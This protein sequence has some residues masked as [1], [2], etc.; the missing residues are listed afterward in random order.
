MTVPY[1]PMP[2]LGLSTYA[3]PNKQILK[4]RIENTLKDAATK[5]LKSTFLYDSGEDGN[6][7]ADKFGQAMSEAAGNIANAIDGYVRGCIKAQ[8]IQI[9][10][11]GTLMSP[12][13]PVT[14][15]LSSIAQ[16]IMIN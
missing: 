13:G 6:E 12:M 8:S 14:G 7:I 10:P 1:V 3:G 15:M 4:Q 9:V 11:K 2:S 16:D 5:A